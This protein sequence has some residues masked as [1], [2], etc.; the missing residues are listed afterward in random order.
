MTPPR[1]L[2]VVALCCLA[3]HTGCAKDK[4][5]KADGS[6]DYMGEPKFNA[7]L[8]YRTGQLADANALDAD[9]AGEAVKARQYEGTALKN[10]DEALKLDAGHRPTLYSLA[11]LRS[12]RDE[13][14]AAAE[15]W[16]RYA[17]AVG[18]TPASLTNLAVAL[19]RGGRPKEA[20]SAYE[21]AVAADPTFQAAQVNLGVLLAKQG[22]ILPARKHLAAV[23]E[24]AAVEWH[25][26][27]ALQAAGQPKLADDR[28][29][30]A[31]ALDPAYATRPD[32]GGTATIRE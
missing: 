5:P 11:L 18:R 15:A 14:P 17:D 2:T 7:D 29:K 21:A 23:L 9:A 28:Y 22:L 30:A 1:L 20:R 4:T 3:L 16:Q 25:L 10:Y 19:E 27:A 8:F 26:G 24:P 32:L 13:W 31:A 12:R 6:A